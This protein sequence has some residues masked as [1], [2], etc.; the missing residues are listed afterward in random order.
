MVTRYGDFVR[1]RPPWK[2]TTWLLWLGPFVLLATALALLL[3]HVRR[4]RP[5]VAALSAAD[6]SRAA[7]ILAGE[8]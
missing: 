5:T 1:Y 7:A 3:T 8:K 2:P 4:R 6:R